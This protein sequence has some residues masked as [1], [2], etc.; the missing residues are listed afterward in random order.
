[1]SRNRIPVRILTPLAF[2]AACG[3]L[4]SAL[5]EPLFS[6]V[7]AGAGFCA[8]VGYLIYHVRQAG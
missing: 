1:M 6:Y 8:V 2:L 4:I 7:L 5:L 3:V